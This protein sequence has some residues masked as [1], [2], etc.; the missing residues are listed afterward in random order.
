MWSAITLSEGF[1]SS[2]CP[3]S[4]AA[5]LMRSG[6]PISSATFGA[7]NSLLLPVGIPWL[8]GRPDLVL[9]MLAG[10]FFAM[11]LDA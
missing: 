5:A 2:F 1:F 4:R 6:N 10:A 7:A 8:L 3:V 9:P 11:L